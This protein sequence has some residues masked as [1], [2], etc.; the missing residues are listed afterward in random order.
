MSW[1]D[2]ILREV[3]ELPDRNSPKENPEAMM[4]T[5]AELRQ[6]IEAHAPKI[7]P[8][9][10]FCYS[11]DA[12]YNEFSSGDDAFN[13]AVSML[14][15]ARANARDDGEWSEE[16]VAITYGAVFGTAVEVSEAYG[17]FDYYISSPRISDLERGKPRFIPLSDEEIIA[18][19]QRSIRFDCSQPYAEAIARSRC[20]ETAIFEK[21]GAIGLPP[22]IES[23]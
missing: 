22:A 8:I 10:F 15:D 20:I 1:I 5:A 14:D 11:Q 12:G 3:A 21:N 19:R 4:V 7:E 18:L 23:D 2:E 13:C 6:I 17:S 16:S 9:K